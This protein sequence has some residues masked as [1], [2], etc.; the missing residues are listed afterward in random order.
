MPSKGWS[1]SNVK[2]NVSSG[3]SSIAHN[4][5]QRHEV[6]QVRKDEEKAV[7]HAAYEAGRKKGLAK[8]A[9]KIGYASTVS[10]GGGLLSGLGSIAPVASYAKSG[11]DNYFSLPSQSAPR[12]YSAPKKKAKGK[13]RRARHSSAT[14]DPFYGW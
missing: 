3:F 6:A 9:Y 2:H 5:K 13:K 11:I 8:N 1:L 7:Q 10:G 14:Y 12:R 4:M